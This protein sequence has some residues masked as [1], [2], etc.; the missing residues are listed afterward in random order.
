M[1]AFTSFVAVE[2]KPRS[3]GE[4]LRRIGVPVETPDGVSYQG[5]LCQERRMSGPSTPSLRQ[6][7]AVLFIIINQQTALAQSEVSKVEVGVME[8]EV[9]VRSAG[10]PRRF[11]RRPLRRGAAG[12]RVAK[13]SA[14]RR[15]ARRHGPA[16]AVE[17]AGSEAGLVTMHKDPRDRLE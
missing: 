5:P 6:L 15:N 14:N 7:L 12:R 17:R 8:S 2:E 9:K 13:T 16:D 4:S 10:S 3:Q 1:T 11:R